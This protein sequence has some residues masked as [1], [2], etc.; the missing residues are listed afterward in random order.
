MTMPET[1]IN[2]AD[3]FMPKGSRIDYMPE[4]KRLTILLQKDDIALAVTLNE[5]QIRKLGTIV[6][7]WLG[8]MRIE[9]FKRRS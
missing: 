7:M 1:S 6:L 8:D 2:I 3:D 5:E 9:D 4:S